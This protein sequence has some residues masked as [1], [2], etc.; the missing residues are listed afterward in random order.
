MK[1]EIRQNGIVADRPAT[2][3]FCLTVY[4]F[5]HLPVA[6]LLHQAGSLLQNVEGAGL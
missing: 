2:I 3:P 6:N 4:Y 5:L 1:K